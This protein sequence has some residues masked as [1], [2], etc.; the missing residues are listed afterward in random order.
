MLRRIP[1]RAGSGTLDVAARS[2]I[3]L[4]YRH[5]PSLR[6]GV[7]YAAFASAK[8]GLRAV[9]QSAARE[10]GPKNLHVALLVIHAGVDTACV[11]DRIK[12]HEG[13]AAIEH[14]ASGRL[15]RPRLWLNAY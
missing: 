13:D 12:K 10:L 11:R 1:G 9:A 3:Y 2:R 4:L 6:G 15:M 5:D 7:G 8:F 14:L